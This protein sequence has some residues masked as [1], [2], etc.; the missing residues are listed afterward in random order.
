MIKPALLASSVCLFAASA[1]FAGNVAVIDVAAAAIVTPAA[2]DW[3]GL[4]AGG[5]VSFD[6]GE[7]QYSK[8][9]SMGPIDELESTTAFGGFAGY[10]IQRGTLVFGGEVAATSGG[11]STVRSSN[12][13]YGP[14]I[15]LKAR[16][17]YSFGKTL[18]YGVAGWSFATFDNG[19]DQF[20]SSGF[21]FGAASM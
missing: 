3:S 13:G 21:A 2:N 14:I 6:S 4:Y 18:A 16:V 1:S 8:G 20:A 19:R 15:D 5:L 7:V 17:G 11:I 9:G 10:N 12:S